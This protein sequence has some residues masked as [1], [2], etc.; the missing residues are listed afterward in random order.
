MKIAILTLNNGRPQT[1]KARKRIEKYVEGK[2]KGLTV[3]IFYANKPGRPTAE[4]KI[5]DQSFDL[6]TCGVSSLEE[7]QIN[8]V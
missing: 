8:I 6:H 4:F 1:K 5:V 3:L 7:K 2:T